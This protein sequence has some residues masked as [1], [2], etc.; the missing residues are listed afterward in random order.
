MRLADTIPHPHCRISI[1]S[2]NEKWIIEIEAGQYKQSYKIAQDSV[3]GLDAVK[4]LVTPRL[5]SATLDRFRSMHEDFAQAF[6]GLNSQ[7]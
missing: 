1:L 7:P 6:A 3:A 4:K 2:W 5:L